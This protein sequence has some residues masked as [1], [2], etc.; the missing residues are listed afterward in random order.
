MIWFI[1]GTDTGVGKT[2]VACAL[3]GM[4]RSRKI[5]VGA[6]KPIATGAVIRRG[7]KISQDAWKLMKA[8]GQRVSDMAEINPV[9]YDPP[10]SPHLAARMARRPV[11]LTRLRRRLIN[12]ERRFDLLIVE[13][14]GGVATPLTD[15][16]TWAD[17]MCGFKSPR[18]VLVCLPKV[19]TLNHTM[20]SLE[21]LSR[22][23]ITCLFLVMA[24]YNPREIRHRENRRE[25]A[26][27]TRL[28]VLV[29]PT[30]SSRLL[31]E[32]PSPPG[33]KART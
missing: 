27:L 7:R 22:R 17:F 14:I 21:F 32:I 24:N 31:G 9:L 12:M 26:R 11:P 15:R 2:T 8:S 10:V 25:L 19:G 23:S 5:R 18:T 20:L 13:G 4:F 28:P 33:I 1:S 29:C 3:A 16:T 6:A 30:G